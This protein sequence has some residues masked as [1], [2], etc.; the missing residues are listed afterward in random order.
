MS[1]PKQ[2][3]DGFQAWSF[4]KGSSDYL[5][6]KFNYFWIVSNGNIILIF[7][8]LRL[9]DTVAG[10]ESRTIEKSVVH[11]WFHVR[12]LSKY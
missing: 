2:G 5:K 4:S 6:H 8:V 11:S 7:Y 1:I 10:G 3:E 12:S 9:S